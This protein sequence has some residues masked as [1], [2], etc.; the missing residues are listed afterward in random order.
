VR[1]FPRHRRRRR[2]AFWLLLPEALSVAVLEPT[3]DEPLLLACAEITVGTRPSPED[4]APGL[5]E[6][7]AAARALDLP[8]VAALGGGY[9]RLER[10]SPAPALAAGELSVPVHTRDDLIA[11]ASSAAIGRAVERFAGA[12]L[13]LAALD[14]APCALL[15]L[16]RYLARGGCSDAVADAAHDDLDPL[17]AVSVAPECERDAA[18]LGHGLAVPVGLALAHFGLVD[19]G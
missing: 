16:A 15:N 5:L 2:T 13:E 7:A 6:T 14:A 12:R 17:T 4:F 9:C 18:R 19:D 1:I 10:C 3:S 8:H 11:V